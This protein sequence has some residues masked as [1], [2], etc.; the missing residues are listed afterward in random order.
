MSNENILFVECSLVPTTILI[1]YLSTLSL[2]TYQILTNI[3]SK[4]LPYNV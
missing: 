1:R 3:E 4:Q 2:S